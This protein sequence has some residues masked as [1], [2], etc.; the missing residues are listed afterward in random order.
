[1]RKRGGKERQERRGGKEKG[2][3]IPNSRRNL[4]QLGAIEDELGD[5]GHVPDGR[6]V[7]ERVAA[8]S[9]LTQ[10]HRSQIRKCCKRVETEIYIW[11]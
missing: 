8:R 5:G 9:D 10:R 3:N 2:E 11:S 6:D 7:D 4:S 1:M